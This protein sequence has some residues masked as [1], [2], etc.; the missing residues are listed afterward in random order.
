M[1]EYLFFSG[2]YPPQQLGSRCAEVFQGLFGSPLLS[3]S[4]GK[5]VERRQPTMPFFTWHLPTTVVSFQAGRS[6]IEACLIALHYLSPLV[7]HPLHD[8]GWSLD[9]PRTARKPGTCPVAN[10]RVLFLKQWSFKETSQHEIAEI[11]FIHKFRTMNL[12]G[13]NKIWDSYLTTGVNGLYFSLLRISLL[14]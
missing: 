8:Q 9:I 14:L 4:L 11:E 1:E 13:L 7:K 10:L 6:I 5:A 3:S 12:P 2:A